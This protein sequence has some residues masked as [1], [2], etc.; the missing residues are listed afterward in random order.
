[1]EIPSNSLVANVIL[2]VAPVI[3]KSDE[4]SIVEKEL[5]IHSFKYTDTDND[6]I[7]TAEITTPVV[8]G[9]YEVLTVINYTDSKKGSKELRMITVVDPEGY[10]YEKNSQDKEVRLD[11]IKV[12]IFSIVNGNSF[13]WDASKY[14]QDN[15]QITDNTGKYSFL[16]PPGK[17]YITAEAGGYK[18]YKSE[19]FNVEDGVGVHFN[20]E[21]KKDE[22]WFHALFDWKMIV[23]VIFGIALILNFI[24]DHRRGKFNN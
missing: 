7:F 8:E 10:V 21:M 18:N 20:I 11:D 9:E 16:V 13:L 17:Y 5:L 3:Q 6:G 19:E 14:N 1:M 15:P 4:T 2:A 12:S 24:Q 22:S 23:I